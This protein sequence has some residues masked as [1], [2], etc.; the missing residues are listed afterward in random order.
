MNLALWD[1]IPGREY[2]PL[3]WSNIGNDLRCHGGDISPDGR[4]LAIATDEGVRFWDLTLAKERD[5]LAV[6]RT[7]DVK[8]HP[9]INELFTSGSSGLR[10]WSLT[11]ETGTLRIGPAHE[12]A[13]SGSFQRLGL[14][15]EGRLLAVV[16]GGHDGGGWV[17]HLG[18][19]PVK[20]PKLDH[21]NA[22]FVA[23]SPDGRWVATGTF[24]GSGVK[25]WEAHNGKLLCHLIPNE[26]Y[27]KVAFSPDA[28][29]LLAQ[30]GSE[31]H[32]WEAG[33][34]QVA[35]QIR[36]VQGGDQLGGT[37]FTPDGKILAASLSSSVVGLFDMATFRLLARLD[38]PDAYLV[39]WLGFSPDGNR[40]V[41]ASETRGIHV[42]DLRR[43][44]AQQKD[45]GLDW[46]MA[47][48]G[49]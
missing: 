22:V 33:S 36:K 18:D 16:G 23:M 9:S 3:P 25:V 2:Q 15:R 19:L 41:A 11:E 31:I 7:I 21:G 8:F 42:W 20:V 5:S 45:M 17:R 37:A 28:R 10:R 44:R 46:G 27:A 12:L 26:A 43:I 29:W 34:W 14:G 47:T 32:I 39:W 4:W 24:H 35:Q 1:V 48:I 49:P 30:T 38:S 40:L 6:G 13:V